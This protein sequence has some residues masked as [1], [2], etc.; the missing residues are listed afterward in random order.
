MKQQRGESRGVMKGAS[1]GFIISLL[2]H[3]GAFLLA[4]LLVVF[5]VVNKEEQKFAPPK[6]VERPKMKL[7]KPKVKVKKNAK[8]KAT[9]RI[10]TKIQK[11]DMPDI[12]LPELGGMG[13]GLEGGDGLGGFDMMPDLGE[14]TMFGNTVSIGNDLVGTFYDIKR[15]RRGRRIPVDT[16]GT[17]W[18]RVIRKFLL[19]GWRTSV[20]AGFYQAPQKLYATSMV[21]PATLSGIAPTAFGDEDAV[22]ALWMVHY[23]GQL[24]HKDGIKFRFWGIGDEFMIVRVGGEIVL[25]AYWPGD[26]YRYVVMP[27]IW[28]TSSADSDKYFMGNE[29]AVVGD[30]VELEPGESKEI[31]ILVGDN[32][33]AACF[34]L[35]VQ[36]EV[37]EYESNLQ[38]APILPVFKTAP[39]THDFLDLVCKELPDEEVDLFNGPIFNDYTTTPPKADPPESPESAPRESPPSVGK[40]DD[41]GMRAWTLADG[42][43]FEAEFVNIIGDKA[44]FKLSNRKTSRLPLEDLS[45]EARLFIELSRPP[46]LDMDFTRNGQQVTFTERN[47]YAVDWWERPAEQHVYFGLRVK[48]TSSGSYDHELHAEMFAVGIQRTN[49]DKQYLLLDRQSTSFILTKENG[50]SFEFKSDHKA[51]LTNFIILNETRGEKYFGYLIVIR[52]E[53]G[54]IIATSASNDWLLEGRENLEKLKVGNYFGKDCI[55]SYPARPRPV[56]QY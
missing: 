50:R 32:G 20:F 1:S 16:D 46:K 35:V 18:R 4:G 27:G 47:P 13:T 51:V 19:S 55:R 37:V 44:V 45:A 39:L 52:D 23:K 33:G 14:V 10:V 2:V 6:P 25:G 31:E 29:K 17:E 21:V 41:L 40:P 24:T 48:Q 30:W 5:T 22:G 28:D 53:R 3:V 26:D 36:E 12:Q 54:E 9:T 15:D 42:R 43:S 11:A 34:I 7:K 49:P 8:P 38:G 56:R